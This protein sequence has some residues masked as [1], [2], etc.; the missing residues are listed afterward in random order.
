MPIPSQA[1]IDAGI[2]AKSPITSQSIPRRAP[3]AAPAHAPRTAAT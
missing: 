1:T 2:R 3:M